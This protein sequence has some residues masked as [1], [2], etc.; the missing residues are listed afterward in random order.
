M[1]VLG[2]VPTGRVREDWKLHIK[3]KKDYDLALGSGLAF[4]IFNEFPFT[5]AEARN[6]L[7]EEG[8]IDEGDLREA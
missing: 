1:T 8:L 4:V 3:C 2:L 5:W 6:I 7:I